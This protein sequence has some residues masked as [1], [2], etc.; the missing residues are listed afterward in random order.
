M[1]TKPRACAGD[2]DRA[3]VFH[4]DDHKSPKPQLQEVLALTL[5]DP[6]YGAPIFDRDHCL[7]KTIVI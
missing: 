3:F 6:H 5:F 4:L 2:Q 1:E 7:V